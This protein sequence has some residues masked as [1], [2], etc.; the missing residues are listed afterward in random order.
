VL[1]AGPHSA[2]TGYSP[3]GSSIC[4]D[5]LTVPTTITGQ[6]GTVIERST[7]VVLAGCKGVKTSATAKPSRKQLLARALARCRRRF[8]HNG[9]R[10]QAC[11]RAA[12]KTF[13]PRSA[14]RHST[15]K[16]AAHR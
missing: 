6:N 13:G 2:L 3:T 1:P 12:R 14:G 4:A 8:R 9:R 16:A 10:R 15:R 11:E 7:P 5:K